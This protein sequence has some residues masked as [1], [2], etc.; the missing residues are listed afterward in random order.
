[1][2]KSFYRKKNVLFSIKLYFIGIR[3]SIKE[4]KQILKLDL[5]YPDGFN[6]ICKDDCGIFRR[7]IKTKN[8]KFLKLKYIFA[9]TKRFSWYYKDIFYSV[10]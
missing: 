5:S 7:H 2:M 9:Q 8:N 3:Q 6:L 10:A 4:S 1:M